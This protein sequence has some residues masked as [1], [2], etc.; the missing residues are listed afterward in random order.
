MSNIISYDYGNSQG[1]YYQKKEKNK[2]YVPNCSGASGCSGVSGASGS[3]KKSP[4]YPSGANKNPEY[5]YVS[6]GFVDK[7]TV[8]EVVDLFITGNLTKNEMDKWL[9]SKCAL[10]VKF[11]QTDSY[12]TY[13]FSYQGK[14][15][16]ISCSNN[17]AYS[18]TDDVVEKTFKY[19]TLK[20]FCT[21][22]QIKD[23]FTPVSTENGQAV[24]Y[25]FKYGTITSSYELKSHINK[26]NEYE[27]KLKSGGALDKNATA[28]QINSYLSQYCDVIKKD[29]KY[30][31]NYS[32]SYIDELFDFVKQDLDIKFYSE[33]EINAIA[34]E[35]REELKSE[36]KFLSSKRRYTDEEVEQMVNKLIQELKDKNNRKFNVK[37]V[38][39]NF[40]NELYDIII[41]TPSY[42]ETINLADGLKYEKDPFESNISAS[43][44]HY[45]IRSCK[46][47]N[48]RNKSAEFFAKIFDMVENLDLSSS[49]EQALY[50]VI[51]SRLGN[52]AKDAYGEYYFSIESLNALNKNDDNSWFDEVYQIVKTEC[53]KVHHMSEN[54][55]DNA[56][57]INVN[58]L[59][60]ACGWKRTLTADD[61]LNNYDRLSISNDPGVRKLT[62]M[63][64]DAFKKFDC[65]FDVDRRDVLQHLIEFINKQYGVTNS[66]PP[67]LSEDTINKLNNNN[68][69]NQIQNIINSQSFYIA[70][71]VDVNGVIG[72]FEQG[73][74]G[75]CWLLSALKALSS[76][77][78]GQNLIKNQIS[79]A[80]DYTSVTV[81]FAG[82]DKYITVSAEE[83]IEAIEEGKYSHG[84]KDVLVI[85]LAME[86]VYGD[87]NGDWPSTFWSRIVGNAN[88]QLDTHV[89]GNSNT[90]KSWLNNLLQNKSQGQNFA[91]TFCLNPGEA[92]CSCSCTNGEPFSY[93]RG[94]H[95]FAITDISST[96]ITFVNPWD[97]STEYIATW[98][99]FISL[100]A[101]ATDTV[102]F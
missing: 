49:E 98:S 39:N 20:E 24:S 28:E 57:K 26:L 42:I 40:N 37:D 87:I 4:D 71:M 44:M 97:S 36:K 73:H 38:L 21:D 45:L 96:T 74:T 76:T 59:R 67:S 6:I 99:E 54:D 17:A 22:A 13:E 85:E 43:N 56:S 66:N 2:D 46:A 61:L 55:I 93:F 82:V 91:A 80:D 11:T 18:Q 84:D 29:L 14:N 15:Y 92:G 8:N 27:T 23:Y 53:S 63:I 47:G 62:Q 32:D 7:L 79:W 78:A 19:Q 52:G 31:Y 16:C 100:G 83:I 69:F 65:V 50:N 94:A 86:K 90:L 64:D 33:N 34:E 9:K 68:I 75:D 25:R 95:A 81:Y 77:P 41:G 72:D 3:N 101:Y 30:K 70:N 12:M 5:I 89:N 60:G 48:S 88:I 1:Y 58:E 102:Y 51:V 10:H 35:Y